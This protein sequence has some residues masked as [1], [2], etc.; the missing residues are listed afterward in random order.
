MN[1]NFINLDNFRPE[2]T[3]RY[4][5][6]TNVWYWCC[7]Q[8]LRVS[9]GRQYQT[10]KYPNFYESILN[11]GAR[12]YYSTV[13][14]VELAN[15]IE[16]NEYNSY[17]EESGSDIS[18]KDFR[19]MNGVR[20]GMRMQLK[21]AW[22]SIKNNGAQPIQNDVI[23][24][25]DQA[26]MKCYLELYGASGI[27]PYDILMALQASKEAAKDDDIYFVTDD[28]DFSVLRGSGLSFNVVSANNS[29]RNF[30]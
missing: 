26:L 1:V 25:F 3:H 21:A 10:S 5:F 19:T 18:R 13:S 9:T 11:A 27:G 6:D 8:S 22:T 7:A 20:D 29:Y 14:F 15:V 28:C 30:W 16:R 24:G 17:V 2:R 4:F 12:V 23:T